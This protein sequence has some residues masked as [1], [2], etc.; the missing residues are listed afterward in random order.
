MAFIEG[1]LKKVPYL[2][3]LLLK[4]NEQKSKNSSQQ[5][6]ADFSLYPQESPKNTKAHRHSQYDIDEII[7]CDFGYAYLG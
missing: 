5:K 7:E 3:D 1:A 6:T 2:R 4:S